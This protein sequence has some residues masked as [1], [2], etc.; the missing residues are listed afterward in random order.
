MARFHLADYPGARE[1]LEEALRAQQAL[2]DLA[3]V[4][5][6]LNYLGL[7]HHRTGDAGTA[8]RVMHEAL[9]VKE[10]IGDRRSLPG[11]INVLGDV[12]RDVFD[13]EL[14]LDHHRR[15]L[16]LA[17]EQENR[18]AQCDNL[19]DL[20]ADHLLRGEFDE[21][22]ARLDEALALAVSIGSA[23]YEA[24]SCNTLGEVALAEDRLDE[25]A[26]WCVRGAGAAERLGA[27]EL[28]AE[29]VWVRSR[30]LDRRGESAVGLALLDQA[31]DQ[32]RSIAHPPFLWRLL[33]DRAGRCLRQ[34]REA[35]AAR[36]RSE[37]R[38]IVTRVLAELEAGPTRERF[39]A[40][41]SVRDILGSS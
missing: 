17:R 3:G 18:G 23:W 26:A 21:A 36:A 25:A 32:F 33:H 24:R 5:V 31:L 15:G 1:T 38:S 19:R 29:A 20:G 16:A 11:A 9:R 22:R 28:A 13:L 41:A 2:G 10:Q 7:L 39:L 34:G 12:Y 35:E 27:R 8:L 40:A 37:A 4:G 6:T 14:A 30:V